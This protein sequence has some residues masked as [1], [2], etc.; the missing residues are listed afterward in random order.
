MRIIVFVLICT[1]WVPGS[2]PAVAGIPTFEADHETTPIPAGVDDTDD[3]AIWLHPDSAEKSLVIGVSKNKKET[4][5]KAGIGIYRL[6]GQLVQYIHHDRLNNVDLRY[7]IAT[8]SGTVDLAVA[9]NRDKKALSLFSISENDIRHIQDIDLRGANNK[10]ISEEPYGSCLG[11]NRQNGRLYSFSPMKSGLIYQHAIEP[12]NGRFQL[13]HIRTIDTARYVTGSLDQHLINIT[14]NEVIWESDLGKTELIAEINE[15]LRD[16]FQLE[17]CVVDDINN[18]LYFGMENLGVFKFNLNARKSERPVLIAK[19]INAK[20]GPDSDRF[21]E[22]VPRI[23][24]DVEGLAILHGP[25]GQG[26][27]IVSVQ[28]LNEF[29]LFDRKTDRYHGSFRLT[30]GTGDAVTETDGLEVLGT[31]LG[32]AYPDGLLAVHDHMNTDDNGQ[33]FNANYKLASL[34]EILNYFPSLRFEGFTYNP[35]R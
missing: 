33:V 8:A 31:P 14:V 6:N 12:S 22:G 3:T 1:A 27:V 28:G 19:V 9:S 35:R 15:E 11:Q 16:R 18:T 20:S 5:G 10:R 4:G 23:V 21:E 32:S 25:D 24:N 2:D 7:G 17:A 30:Y 29:A 34:T 26:A 13:R